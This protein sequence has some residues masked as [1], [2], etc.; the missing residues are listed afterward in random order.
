MMFHLQDNTPFLQIHPETE[1]EF[2]SHKL[3]LEIPGK[4]IEVN[5]VKQ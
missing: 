4:Q 1:S 2:P 3:L 5:P